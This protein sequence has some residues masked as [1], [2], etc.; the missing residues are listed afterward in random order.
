MNSRITTLEKLE[1]TMPLGRD[2]RS[3]LEETLEKLR[4]L[5]PEYYL[6]LIDQSDPE[7]PIRKLVI[8]TTQ[9]LSTI[10]LNDSSGEKANTEK[11]GIR[12]LQHKYDNT[13]LILSTPACAAYCRFCFRKR[14]TL[15]GGDED[16]AKVDWDAAIKY[17]QEHEEIDNVLISGGDALMLPNSTLEERLGQLSKIEHLNLI[18]LGTKVPAFDPGRITENDELVKILGKYNRSEKSIY[19]I[20]HYEHPRE[21]TEESKKAI[22]KLKEAGLEIKNQTVLLKGVNDKPE[23][24]TELFNKLT[25][26]GVTPYYIF[27]LRPVKGVTHFRVP[28]TE[29][30]RI[31]E[32]AK[33]RMSGLAKSLRY[34][35]SHDTGKIEILG[36]RGEN[37]VLKYHQARNP[38]DYGKLFEAPIKE[39]KYW[40]GEHQ[41][42]S[43]IDERKIAIKRY[44][45]GVEIPSTNAG[46]Y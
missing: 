46:A 44:G 15:E 10:G 30:I 41:E 5:I 13:A 9:E 17:I 33:K 39:N 37:L 45:P 40:F 3:D 2:E 32:E 35:M 42:L 27:Q 24:L 38:N 43:Q 11:T 22:Y 31:F 6:N 1:E 29:G 23:I 4:M 19:V 36:I 8:P 12:G 18:R 28:I 26:I 21:I 34:V 7:D 20:A 14:F 25:R 16:E